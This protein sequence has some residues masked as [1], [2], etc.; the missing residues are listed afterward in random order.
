MLNDT[1]ASRWSWTPKGH[2]SLG[3]MW[4][5]WSELL[6]EDPVSRWGCKWRPATSKTSLSWCRSAAL[7]PKW[8]R[9][10]PFSKKNW[11]EETKP[12]DPQLRLDMPRIGARRKTNWS[13]H[14]FHRRFQGLAARRMRAGSPELKKRTFKHEM[15]L[16]E[17]IEKRGLDPKMLRKRKALKFHQMTWAAISRHIMVRLHRR[18]LHSGQCPMEPLDEALS[19][20]TSESS[21]YSAIESH[22]KALW[23]AYPSQIAR[24]QVLRQSWPFMIFFDTSQHLE[25]QLRWTPDA[26]QPM[27]PSF[28]PSVQV[29]RFWHRRLHPTLEPRIFCEA[30]QLLPQAESVA[31][32]KIQY[33]KHFARISDTMRFGLQL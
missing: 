11:R 31:F 29:D 27:A 9:H 13:F 24:V 3:G 5:Q 7:T 16:K 10:P 2:N 23:S 22:Q 20:E 14:L 19:D 28:C 17:E 4:A 21:R 1:G 32:I 18:D 26:K 12:N 8:S 25:L 30:W 33:L 6:Q 15:L